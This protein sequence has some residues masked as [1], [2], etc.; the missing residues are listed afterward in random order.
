M[1]ERVL[2]DTGPLVAL[3]SADDQHHER[4]RDTL[5]GLI[6]PL[7]TCWP[8]VTEVAWLLRTRPDALHKL[9]QGFRGG[10]FALLLLDAED[11]PAIAALMR[12]Y[13]SAGLQFADAILAHLAEREQIHTIFTTDRR[14]FSVIRLKRNRTLRLI[15]DI[16]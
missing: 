15:P 10:L 4:C 11:L 2:I 3:F 1:A 9:F 16:P 7:L 13:E 12:R 14:D 5:N 8:V 6:P